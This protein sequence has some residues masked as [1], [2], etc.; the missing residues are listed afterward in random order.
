MKA[1][2]ESLQLLGMLKEHNGWVTQ[3]P[4]NPKFSDMVLSASRGEK[5]VIHDTFTDV[6]KYA[7]TRMT[8]NVSDKKGRNP[9]PSKI[10]RTINIDHIQSYNPSVA[11]YRREYTSNKSV[12]YEEFKEHD[13]N[14]NEDN[15]KEAT[16]HY[17]Y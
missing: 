7:M 15:L 2:S 8:S 1:P 13:P 5:I 9:K 4:T 3:I 16:L 12:N 14:H 10:D 6:D 17:I 11:Y